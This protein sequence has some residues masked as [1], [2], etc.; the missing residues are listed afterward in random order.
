M[1][2]MTD[3]QEWNLRDR[4]RG[5][6]HHAVNAVAVQKLRCRHHDTDREVAELLADHGED[7]ANKVVEHLLRHYTIRDR[8]RRARR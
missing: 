3:R 7:I 2:R 6:A 5:D 1:A 4:I 8:V